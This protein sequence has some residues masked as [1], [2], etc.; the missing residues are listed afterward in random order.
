MQYK[1]CY[2]IYM[3]LNSYLHLSDYVV[4]YQSDKWNQLKNTCSKVVGAKKKNKEAD[5]DTDV[6]PSGIDEK[7]RDLTAAELQVTCKTG[8]CRPVS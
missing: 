1:Q 2:I 8:T 7:L 4:R 5:G 6:L 3:L